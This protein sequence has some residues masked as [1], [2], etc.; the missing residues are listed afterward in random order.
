MAAHMGFIPKAPNSAKG[1]VKNTGKTA[2]WVVG[3]ILALG[4]VAVALPYIK[5]VPIIG[6]LASKGQQL[7]PDQ[8]QQMTV[9]QWG[10]VR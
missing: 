7:V 6:G 4:V 9:D 5:R 1:F 2:V 3:G 8:S 10:R